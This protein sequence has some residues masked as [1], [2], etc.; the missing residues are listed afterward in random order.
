[1]FKYSNVRLSFVDLKWAQLHI[2]L[3]H[4]NALLWHR[5]F[6]SKWVNK[7]NFVMLKAFRDEILPFKEGRDEICCDHC[8]QHSCISFCQLCKFSQRTTH[9]L[10]STK[11]THTISD[12]ST[13][14]ASVVA[15]IHLYHPIWPSYSIRLSK[16]IT[17]YIFE[18]RLT[19]AVKMERAFM[20]S[21]ISA[22]SDISPVSPVSPIRP[23]QPRQP[24]NPDEQFQP[25]HS[26]NSVNSV[27]HVNSEKQVNSVDSVSSL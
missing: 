8:V 19:K 12:F 24:H 18:L 26:V 17:C 13:A 4:C 23:P 16:P 10:R 22:T 20:P 7:Y 11:S 25:H 1:M 21:A 27:N 5:F 2:S 9:F 14:D 15:T 3:V 6:Y